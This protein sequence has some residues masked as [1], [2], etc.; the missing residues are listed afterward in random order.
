MNRQTDRPMRT[1][2]LGERLS[3]SFSPQIHRALVGDR[4][5]YELFERTPGEVEAFIKGGF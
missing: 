2:L 1:G 3:H 4:Y 5:T